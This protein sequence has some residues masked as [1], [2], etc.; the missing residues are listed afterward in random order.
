MKIPSFPPPQNIRAAAASPLRGRGRG[1]MPGPS[2]N[3]PGKNAGVIMRGHRPPRGATSGAR[4]SKTTRIVMGTPP[5]V[6]EMQS[7]KTPNKPIV[8]PSSIRSAAPVISHKKG[9]EKPLG[10]PVPNVTIPP[11]MSIPISSPSS[12]FAVRPPMGE[13]Q[14]R[15][16]SPKAVRPTLPNEV[17]HCRMPPTIGQVSP[18]QSVLYAPRMPPMTSHSNMTPPGT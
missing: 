8:P 15:Q 11:Q 6:S 14:S 18:P 10:A 17:M 4:G 7:S 9:D 2:V 5:R 12:S 3:G 1:R 13:V 16:R